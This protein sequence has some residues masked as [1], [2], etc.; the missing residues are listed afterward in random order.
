MIATSDTTIL[1]CSTHLQL[2]TLEDLNRQG[3][4][5]DDVLAAIVKIDCATIQGMT[6]RFVG[7]PD[8]WADV[9]RNGTQGLMLLAD[10]AS[11]VGYWQFVALDD[12]TF[13]RALIGALFDDEISS[14]NTRSLTA[15]GSIRI[16]VVGVSVLAA[17]RRLAGRRLL[18]EG[19]GRVLAKLADAGVF[20]REICATAHTLEGI[21]LARSFGLR[22][23]CKHAEHGSVYHGQMAD[24]MPQILRAMPGLADHFRPQGVLA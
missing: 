17:Y 9:L 2:L 7:H 4:A 16:C 6:R 5:T 20:V 1:P 11:V 19:F 12:D 23:V 24:A 13:D 14:T 15:P 3:V 21:A 10:G 22:C 18:Y 8:Q